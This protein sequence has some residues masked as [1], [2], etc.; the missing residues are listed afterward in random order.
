[1]KNA[2]FNSGVTPYWNSLLLGSYVNFHPEH[3]ADDCVNSGSVGGYLTNQDPWQC[4][5]LTS[6]LPQC[7]GGKFYSSKG[8]DSTTCLVR[9]YS[10]STCNE[11]ALS[12]FKIGPQGTNALTGWA[13]YVNSNAVA[14]STAKS[15]LIYVEFGDPLTI[16]GGDASFVDQIYLN[17][18]CSF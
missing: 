5:T 2:G 14:P 13:S 8:G 1:V 6:P 15:A 4:V 7:F 17:T 3:D 10:N 12:D 9:Y 16:D 18:S 11:P